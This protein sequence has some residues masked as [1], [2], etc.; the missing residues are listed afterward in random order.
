MYDLSREVVVE[1]ARRAGVPHMYGAVD[2]MYGAAPG[3]DQAEFIICEV[4]CRGPGLWERARPAREAFVSM[5]ARVA[6][7]NLEAE[8]PDLHLPAA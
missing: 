2:W 3:R 4:N 6:C 7:Q 1:L 8:Q 5:I